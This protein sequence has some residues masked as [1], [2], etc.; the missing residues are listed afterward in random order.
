MIAA[1]PGR[2]Q[3]PMSEQSAYN[4]DLARRAWSAVSRGDTETLSEMLAPDVVWH[5]T[6]ANPWRGDH[7]GI[8]EILDY[9]GRIGEM[10]ESFDAML[11]DVLS[12]EDRA[13]IVF[14]ARLERGSRRLDVGYLLLA[15]IASGRAAEVWTVPLDPSALTSFWM[16]S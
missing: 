10:T 11:V 7:E 14:R 2:A 6:G 8:A 15:R 3:R 1:Q 5:A 16:D 9:L 4:E 13:T 12:S